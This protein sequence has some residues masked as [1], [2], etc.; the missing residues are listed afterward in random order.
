VPFYP[1]L[2]RLP[3]ATEPRVKLFIVMLRLTNVLS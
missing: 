3:F 1:K 2:G